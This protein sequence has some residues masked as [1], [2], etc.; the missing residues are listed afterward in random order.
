VYELRSPEHFQRRELVAEASNDPGW[1]GEAHGPRR[2]GKGN[3]R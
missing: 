3:G 1:I 2:T